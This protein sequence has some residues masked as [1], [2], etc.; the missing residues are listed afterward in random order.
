MDRLKGVRAK[1]E[2]AKKHIRDL[3]GEI[4]AVIEGNPPGNRLVSELDSQ[5]GD[6]IHRVRL[7]TPIPD[8]ISVLVG[9]AL[10]NLRATLDHLLWQ[11]V[12]ANGA[13][14]GK[15]HYFPLCSTSKAYH[16][17]VASGKIAGV[18]T[19][20]KAIFEAVQ[21][22]QTGY[23]LLGALAELNNIDKHRALIFAVCQEA[24]TSVG[25]NTDSLKG[26][27]P[28]EMPFQLD[29][30]EEGPRILKDGDTYCRSMVVDG[31]Q[32]NPYVDFTFTI[33]FSEPQIVRGKPVFGTLAEIS[34]LLDGVLNQF[35]P[36]V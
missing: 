8:S 28:G 10:N 34:Q 7:K 16:A 27:L 22:Y 29:F 36:F 6:V 35:S 15:S 3:E 13:V 21:P 24:D 26:L 32:P 4:A 14:G 11:L 31:R 18:S 12:E 9:D 2:R 5:T 33:A 20:C 1:A 23:E 25:I 19:T 17:S 30:F